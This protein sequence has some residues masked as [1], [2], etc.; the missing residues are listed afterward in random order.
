MDYGLAFSFP[1]KDTQWF[2]KLIIPGL[3]SL[4]PIVGQFFL[5]GFGL[6][7]AKRVIEKNPEDLPE[8]D[9]GGDL[10]RGFLAFVIGLGY[11]LP[12]I[13]LSLLMSIVLVAV[14]GFSG[15]SSSSETIMLIVMVVQICFGF[16]AIIY[17]LAMAFFNSA[18]LGNFL[19]NGE[20]LGAAF[21]V[22]EIW[23]Y[24]KLAIV[25]YL[26]VIVG[27]FVANLIGSLGSIICIVGL[28]VTMP[29]AMAVYGHFIGQAYNA[30]HAVKEV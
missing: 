14:G 30:A 12:I 16:V 15:E 5:M 18:A 11:G 9:F 21:R 4:I 10:K 3:V 19:A 8:F 26:L 1:F 17:G 28:L 24:L 25:P 2:K 7:V 22:K 27:G 20:Q 13:L 6:N 29:Y 23:D